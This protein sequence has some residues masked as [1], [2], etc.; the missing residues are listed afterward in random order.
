MFPAAK[1]GLNIK[2]P[3]EDLVKLTSARVESVS[4]SADG[5]GS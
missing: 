2:L 4:K 3:V 5:A 1:R